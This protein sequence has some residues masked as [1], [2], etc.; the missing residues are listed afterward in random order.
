MWLLTLS[1]CLVEP[2]EPRSEQAPS[3]LASPST[4]A[5][6]LDPVAR[7]NRASMLLRGVRPTPEEALRVAED[8]EVLPELVDAWTDDPRFGETVRDLHADVLW[9]RADARISWPAE[10]PVAHAQETEVSDSFQE[11]PLVL[12]EHVVTNDRPYTEILTADYTLAD[13]LVAAMEGL[14]YDPDGPEWQVTHHVDGRPQSG[15]LSST[16]LW[17]RWWTNGSGKHRNRANFVSLA[18]LCDEIGALDMPVFPEVTEDDL[19]VDSDALSDDPAC[20][21]CHVNLD[22]LAA[23][24]WPY[25]IALFGSSIRK[26]Y[27]ADCAGTDADHCY[28]IAY[29]DQGRALQYRRYDLPAPGFYGQSTDDLADLGQA[30]AADERFAR[31]AV[32]NAW[33][34]LTQRPVQELPPSLEE[35]LTA[36]F[37]EGYDYRQLLQQIAL[38][39]AAADASAPVLQARPEVYQRLVEDLTGQ[40]WVLSTPRGDLDVLSSSRNGLRDLAGGMDHDHVLQPN[41]HPNPTAMLSFDAVARLAAE[42][43]VAEGEVLD[44]SLEE[45]D[46]VAAQVRALASVATG[47]SLSSSDPLVAELELLFHDALAALGDPAAAWEVTLRALLVDPATLTY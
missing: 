13:D 24:F 11:A 39:D 12:V 29:Y 40:R 9:M 41:H 35:E 17:Q 5:E 6:V 27:E 20:A 30:L 21:V 47:R 14:P 8:P 25:E 45:P 32:D 10:G 4:V 26:A 31:C 43:A 44:P 16:G 46:A 2:S 42:G 36:S 33:A 23:H 38:S 37:R 18:F 22:P 28:P 15:L 19:G 1:A 3:A 7:A 34:Y